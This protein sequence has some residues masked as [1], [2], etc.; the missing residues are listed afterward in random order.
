MTE[1][2]SSDAPE[3]QVWSASNTLTR[4]VGSVF[5]NLSLARL[6]L[7]GL[8]MSKKNWWMIGYNAAM[9]AKHNTKDEFAAAMTASEPA[10][11][12]QREQFESGWNSVWNC[13]RAGEKS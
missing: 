5:E 12:F 9:K 3:P 1:L 8:G 4:R 11:E 7:Y 2:S 13:E 10:T 6:S